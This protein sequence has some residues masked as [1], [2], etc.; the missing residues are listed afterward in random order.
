MQILRF[1]KHWRQLQNS[2][3]ARLPRPAANTDNGVKTAGRGSPA[4]HQIAFIL[5]FAITSLSTLIQSVKRVYNF[6]RNKDG[7]Q[8]E[9]TALTLSPRSLGILEQLVSSGRY[10]SNQ[11]ALEEAL[12][13]LEE[14][15]NA[16]S[17]LPPHEQLGMTREELLRELNKADDTKTVD[18]Q[19][20]EFIARMHEK[21]LR[22]MR[23]RL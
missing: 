5:N 21:H 18:I 17:G 15:E 3:R 22:K 20:E 9:K 4:L 2:C 6:N 1:E 13:L 23:I 14:R 8:N 16:F 7:K 10:S 19:A 11:E 12:S